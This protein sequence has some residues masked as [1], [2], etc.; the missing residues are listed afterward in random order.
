MNPNL[1]RFYNRSPSGRLIVSMLIILAGGTLMLSLFLLAGNLIFNGSAGLLPDQTP[2]EV[3]NAPGFIKY[4]LIAQDLS[5]FII[6]AIIILAGIDPVYGSEIINPEKI[7][8]V[9]VL[10][11]ALLA[12]CAFPVTGLASQLNSSMAL[13]H[14][15]SGVEHWMRDKE[16]YADHLLEVIMTPGTFSGMMF[17]ILLIAALPAIGEELIFRGILQ[18]AFQYLFRSGH[19]AVW[20]TGIIFSALHFQFY[21]FLPRLLLGVIFGYLFLWGKNIWLPVAA[22]FIN[23]A[24]PTAGSYFRGWEAINSQPAYNAAKQI[25]FA[26]LAFVTCVVILLW[27]R[28]RSGWSLGKILNSL[29]R[30]CFGDYD[31]FILKIK[32]Q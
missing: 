27:F 2:Q 32:L 30:K 1:S 24:V 17:N 6:P 14:S 25:P 3:L 19:A 11:V 20:I 26:V 9:E 18:K 31:R 16:D 23:N 4:A 15:L 5:Y 8:S 29:L 21:G 13:P 28:G 7:S 22:H 12:V 10:L